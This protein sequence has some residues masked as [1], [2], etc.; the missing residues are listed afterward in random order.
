MRS[1]AARGHEGF[2]HESAFYDSDDEFLALVVPF[3]EG[4]LRAGEPTLVACSAENTALL[5]GALGHDRAITFLPAADQYARPVDTIAQYRQIL[6]E[7]M[8]A[9]ASQ[10]RAIGDV[11]HPGAGVPWNW[12]ARYEAAANE[13]Y[14]EF[15]LWGLCPYDT[16]TTPA[17][18][19]ADVVRTHPHTATASGHRANPG[20]RP[21]FP[22]G[23]P[24][25]DVLQ[26]GPALVELVNAS[27]AAV[28][29]A[30][31]VAIGAT[32]LN[33]TAAHDVVYAASELVTNGLNHGV[34]PVAFR[35]WADESRVVVTVTDQGTG[36]ADPC[37][38]LMPTTV[39]D[40]AGLGLWLLHRTCDYVS[41]G[42]DSHGFTVRAV[43]GGPLITG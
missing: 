34:T 41:M 16:R 10:V 15:P 19:L 3:V 39:T 32:R 43:V 18:V 9:G 29:R 22:D 38:G 36:P 5:Q 21:G 35:L 2:F 30:V 23:T 7:H 14:A 25:P 6:T 28:R 40:S 4:G 13:A 8:A 31:G 33:G 42:H 11:P 37:A 26:R 20:F 17:D 27:P 24:L 1:G 12:W